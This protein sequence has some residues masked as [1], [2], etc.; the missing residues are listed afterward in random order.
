M[1]AA[2]IDKFALYSIAQ[3]CDGLV[4]DGS[5]GFEPRYTFNGVINTVDDAYTVLNYIASSFR[6]MLYWSAGLVTATADSPTAARKLVAPANVV[7]GTFTYTGTSAKSRYSVAI[8]SFLN[9]ADSYNQDIVAYEDPDLIEI[10]GWKPQNIVAYGCTSR[11]Q[12][13]RYAKWYIDTQKYST[14]IVTY[15]ASYD[16]AD[17]LPGQVIDVSDPSY[18]GV[19]YGGRLTSYS[20]AADTLMD[21]DGNDITDPNGNPITANV[22]AFVLDQGITLE[23]GQTYTLSCVMPDGTI[24]TA[25][26]TNPSDDTVQSVITTST[27][28]SL[29]PVAGAMWTVTAS[30]L[31]P[32]QFRVV[33][34]KDVAKNIFEIVAV[35]YDPTKYARVEENV[36]ITPPNFSLIPQGTLAGPTSL[37]VKEYL[38]KATNGVVHSAVT[39]SWSP[40]KDPRISYYQIQMGRPT[41]G[42][43]ENTTPPTST[44]ASIDI[45]GLSAG[46]YQFQVR[47]VSMAGKFSPWTYGEFTLNGLTAPPS[48]VTNFNIN[49][50]G[51]HSTLSWSGITDLNLSHYI[52]QYSSAIVGATWGASVLL[53][54]QISPKATSVVV[55]TLIGTYLIKAVSTADK[56]STNADLI[57][58]NIGDIIQDNIIDVLTEDS[59]FLGTK[60]NV[61]LS[62]P[63]LRLTDPTQ[64]GT[65]YFNNSIDM[66]GLYTARI[67]PGITALGDLISDTMSSW[68][69]LSSLSFMAEADPSAWNTTIQVRTTQ[70]DPWADASNIVNVS[71]DFA[72]AAWTKTHSS[73]TADSTTSPD[74]TAS[75]DTLTEDNTAST[76]HSIN[77][78]IAFTT[79]LPYTLSVYAKVK[80]RSFIELVLPSAAF[81]GN[82]TCYFNLTTGV[83]GTPSG[84]TATCTLLGNGWAHCTITATSTSSASGVFEIRMA[85]DIAT[86]SYT[87]DNASGVYLWQPQV[88]QA[89]AVYAPTW[90]AWGNVIIGDYT[91]RAFQFSIILDS[92]DGGLTTPLITNL[93]VTVDIPTR[94]E[95]GVDITT[96]GGGVSAVTYGNAFLNSPGVTI[97]AHNM[98]TGDYWTITGKT[99]AG[100]T[101]TFYNSSN[102]TVV[103]TFDWNA[104]GFGKQL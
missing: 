33:S 104:T 6:G 35:Y 17:V 63:N 40:G 96:N 92:L 21:P 54:D 87:G 34:I 55:P 15:R 29:S 60:T 20:S 91:C 18:A 38:Y 73:V 8:V 44:G 81:S 69:T 93:S 1:N 103:R 90:T 16:N 98:A 45:L 50:S 13:Y 32:R 86:S 46:L 67:V 74:G 94:S 85:T 10:M 22:T 48:D 62:G 95:R 100:F 36:I 28:F 89:A 2:S 49:N 9:P 68:T 14:E 12:A 26:I 41:T 51:S 56:E 101:I 31:S 11:G 27:V 65:Y 70:N 76:T 43:W 39:L 80:N 19:R 57:V 88:T 64:S 97:A 61:E 58:S 59:T 37:S 66:G 25:P 30:N 77:E 5:G 7:G 99:N 102:A 3:Y 84:C 72:D 82:P 71:T 4:P 42:F 78:S 23:S 47:A 83:A 52:V 24:Q 75:A 79:G 53:V